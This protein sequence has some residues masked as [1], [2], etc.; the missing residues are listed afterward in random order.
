[1]KTVFFFKAIS[2]LILLLSFNSCNNHPPTDLTKNSIIPK[3]FSVVATQGTFELRD[4]AVIYVSEESNELIRV[5]NYFASMLNISTG[6]NIAVKTSAS[7]PSKGN[8][9]FTLTSGDEELGEEGYELTISDRLVHLAAN[10]PAGLMRGIQTLRQLLP[11]KVEADNKQQGPWLIATG[12]IRDFPEYPYRGVM[13]DV[14]R[15]FFGVEDVKRYIDHLAMYKMNILHLHLSDDQGWRIEI[16]S[17]PNLT[18]H[19][20]ST[21]V[22]GGAGGFYTQEEFKE[23]VLYAQDRYITIVP[24]IDMPGHTNAA[25][26]SYPELNRDGKAPELYTGIKV[27]FSTLDTRKEVVYQFVDDV[28]RE[29]SAITPGPYFHIGGDESHVTEKADY[30]YFVNRVQAIVK[31]H[32]KFTIGWDEIANATLT[33]NSVIQYWAEKKDKNAL[34]AVSQGSKIIMSPSTRAY[35]D[36]KYDSLTVLGLDWAG[37]IEVDHAYDWDPA[38]LVEGVGRKD[39]LG[40]EAPLWSE[41]VTNIDEIEHL[42]F[43]RIAGYAEIGWTKPDMRNWDEYK[44]RLAEQKE[45]FETMGINFYPS[46]MVPWQMNI[47]NEK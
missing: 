31:S 41:T 29:L 19:G 35:L 23:I 6:F 43:P 12:I 7:E 17:W 25:L 3:P 4:D 42:V 44:V 36:M 14:A 45:R 22:G 20:G 9:Y 27:G 33:D 26:A 1:M 15:H 34:L 32:G 8:L 5:G 39:I 46:P 13:L 16:K 21:Q 40:I 38:T 30:I 37:T 10:N 24:E 2:A 28:V 47:E 11:A 18:K